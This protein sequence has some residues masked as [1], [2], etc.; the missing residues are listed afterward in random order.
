MLRHYTGK[1][2][3]LKTWVDNFLREQGEGGERRPES[4]PVR[5]NTAARQNNKDCLTFREM[6]KIAIEKEHMFRQNPAN[7]D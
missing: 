5:E 6:E 4:V 1:H 7:F 3:V 2:N